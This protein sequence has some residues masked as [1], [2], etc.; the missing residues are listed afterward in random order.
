MIRNV[1]CDAKDVYSLFSRQGKRHLYRLKQA[2]LT[3]S[4]VSQFLLGNKLRFQGLNYFL[5]VLNKGLY[6]MMITIEIRFGFAEDLIGRSTVSTFHGSIDQ[7]KRALRIFDENRM[8][9]GV[10]DCA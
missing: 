9:A 7:G 3:G 6:L 2:R 8:R 10:Y 5:V 4:R 1:R